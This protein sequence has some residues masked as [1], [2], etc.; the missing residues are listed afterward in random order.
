[1]VLCKVEVCDQRMGCE[2]GNL[3]RTRRK[4]KHALQCYWEI[5]IRKTSSS[6]STQTV[7]T[8]ASFFFFFLPTLF[9]LLLPILLLLQ[10][11]LFFLFL[12]VSSVWDSFLWRLSLSC[13]STSGS[14]RRRENLSVFV[15][16]SAPSSLL[17]V[18]FY[19]VFFPFLFSFLSLLC[20]VLF[21]TLMAPYPFHTC[22]LSTYIHIYHCMLFLMSIHEEYGHVSH[23]LFSYP[24]WSIFVL[25]CPIGPSMMNMAMF[26]I[27]LLPY[28]FYISICILIMSYLPIHGDYDHVYDD[29]LPYPFTSICILIVSNLLIHQEYGHVSDDLLLYPFMFVCILMSYLPIHQ[30]YGHAFDWF[31]PYIHFSLF[32]FRCHAFPSLKKMA[33]F[34]MTYSSNCIYVRGSF[35]TICLVVMFVNNLLKFLLLKY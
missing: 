5:S 26:L 1:M 31:Y 29:P 22:F 8:S 19:S 21:S 18:I 23:D 30:E 34:L 2:A 14:F 12:F 4:T 3:R 15:F 24:F 25:L 13:L 11:P 17:S 28:P 35:H 16:L 9:L 32:V 33:I 10:P 20:S 7:N 6:S 27:D